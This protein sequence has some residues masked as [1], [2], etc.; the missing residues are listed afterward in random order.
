MYQK[1]TGVFP[2]LQGM[3]TLDAALRNAPLGVQIR[4]MRVQMEFLQSLDDS[5]MFGPEIHQLDCDISDT[6]IL[7][8]AAAKRKHCV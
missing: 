5:P 6:G 2:N 1:H 8:T 7:Q 3:Y 4:A